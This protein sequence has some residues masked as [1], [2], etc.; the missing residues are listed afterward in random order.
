MLMSNFVVLDKIDF[1]IRW[2]IFD[3]V[4]KEITVPLKNCFFKEFSVK[5]AW[6]CSTWSVNTVMVTYISCVFLLDFVEAYGIINCFF[7]PL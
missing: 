3:R 1:A 6:K 2:N 7:P 4:F 5:N